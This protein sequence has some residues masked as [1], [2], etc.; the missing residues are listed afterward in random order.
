MNRK[1]S[2]ACCGIIA[3][4]VL[5]SWQIATFP[6]DAPDAPEIVA[7]PASAPEPEALPLPTDEPEALPLPT[8]RDITGVQLMLTQ[9]WP[10]LRPKSK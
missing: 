10:K 7:P 6:A 9:E 8:E 4:W 5:L 2:Y 1:T 3:C